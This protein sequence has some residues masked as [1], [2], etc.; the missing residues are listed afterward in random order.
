M[1][2]TQYTLVERRHALVLQRHA[3]VQGRHASAGL[4]RRVA[5]AWPARGFTIIELMITMVIL[6]I[7]A[8]VA[9]PSMLDMLNSSRVRSAASDLYESAILAR[10]EA[11][12]R[13]TSVDVVPAATGWQDGWTVEVGATVI[14][15]H[16]A[17][18]SV[19]ITPSASGNLTYRL[20]GRV[21][22]S[23]RSFVLSSSQ[24]ASVQA[25]CIVIDASGRA[26]IKTD[27]DSN[28]SDGCD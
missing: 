19:T 15:G 22:T 21:S 17:T 18:P 20:D 4:P 7:L 3:F 27:R 5:T 16:D 25:R 23:L 1:V 10:S 28:P 14:S 2:A 8:A 12:K 6:A 11:I 9:G 26:G 13:S 24:S